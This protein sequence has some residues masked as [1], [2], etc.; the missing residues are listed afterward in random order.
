ML[1]H[2]SFLGFVEGLEDCHDV[3]PFRVGGDF[4]VLT[5]PNGTSETPSVLSC[6]WA[7]LNTLLSL[8]IDPSFFLHH[9]QIDRLWWLWQQ[10]DRDRRLH[11]YQGSPEHPASP[12]DALPYEP[13]SADM[14]VW[15]VLSTETEI[16]CYRY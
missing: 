3:V 10:A 11:A 1:N 12:N 5:A 16:L 15:D 6:R 9:T 7:H 2:D 4:M 13:L 14:A 8:L